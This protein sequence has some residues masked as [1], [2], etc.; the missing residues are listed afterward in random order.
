MLVPQWPGEDDTIMAE[1]DE[2]IHHYLV[3]QGPATVKLS[4]ARQ[5]TLTSWSLAM[6]ARRE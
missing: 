5:S 4:A 3:R 6:S 1:S 2:L